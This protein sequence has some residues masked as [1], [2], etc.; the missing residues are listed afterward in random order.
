[1][2]FAISSILNM[3]Q[4]L[5]LIMLLEKNCQERKGKPAF[6][7]RSVKPSKATET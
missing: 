4:T 1:M 7:L 6:I 5:A 2:G 3:K